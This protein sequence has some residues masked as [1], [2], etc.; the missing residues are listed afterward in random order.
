MCM[1]VFYDIATITSINYGL[2]V[3]ENERKG[4]H[5][6]FVKHK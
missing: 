6:I 1:Y 4:T 5:R 2:Y 3:Y